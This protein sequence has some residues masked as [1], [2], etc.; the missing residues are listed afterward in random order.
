MFSTIT[1]LKNTIAAF[2]VMLLLFEF[3]H[4]SATGQRA[5]YR[6]NVNEAP[7]LYR[8][9]VCAVIHEL[10][11]TREYPGDFFVQ[12]PEIPTDDSVIIIN[13]WHKSA[14]EAVHSDIPGNPGGKCR[15]M[16]YD[17]RSRTVVKVQF[18][19]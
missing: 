19:Q 15:D 2:A 8:E 18:W 17:T 3:P 5:M 9:S 7:E 16:Y 6:L 11:K 1:L 13:L 10:R 14:L 4:V 12:F